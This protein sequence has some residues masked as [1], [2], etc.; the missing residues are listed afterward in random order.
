MMSID[1]E[2]TEAG[3]TL[4]QASDLLRRC[5]AIRVR[6]KRQPDLG[7]HETSQVRPNW[8]PARDS[9]AVAGMLSAEVVNKHVPIKERCHAVSHWIECSRNS[10]M[11][12][13]AGEAGSC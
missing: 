11:G 8:L 12:A 9:S 6:H 7:R 10:I 4:K 3:L 2:A 1:M 13:N 5:C